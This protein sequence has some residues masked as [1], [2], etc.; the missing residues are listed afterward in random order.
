MGID[1]SDW[2]NSY[3]GGR[4]QAVIAND[5]MSEP[6]TVNCGVPQGSILGPLLFLCFVNDLP[7]S[8][9]NICK[10]S[11]Y[12]DDTQLIVSAKTLPELKVKIENVI[13]IAERW[14]SRNG[15]KNNA[16]KSEV[17]LISNKPLK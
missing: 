11:A 12:A 9:E 5:T 3:L 4:Q 16:G 13:Q 6:C 1:F 10:F 2:F 8:F 14:Y 7:N 17:I 15:M